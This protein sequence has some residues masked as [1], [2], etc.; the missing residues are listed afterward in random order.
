M[1]TAHTVD[2]FLGGRIAAVQPDDG[3]HR[4]G[5][6]AVLL[7]AAL[8]SSFV[9]T[10]VD[11]GAGA[12]VAGLC[13]AARCAAASVVLV[14]RDPAA[15]A[16]S[17]A[18]IALPENADVA[19]RVR[20]VAADIVAPEAQRV[21]AGLGRDFADA[22]ITNPPFN[23]GD[24]GTASPAPGRSSAHVLGDNVLD[25]WMRTAAS[26]LRPGGVLVVAFRAGGLPALLA[27][28]AGR[29]GALAIL[30]IHPRA[31]RPAHRVLVRGVKGSRTPT[32][33]L[34]GLTLH[35]ATGN[36]YL[37]NV[38]SMLRDGAGLAD[39]HPSWAL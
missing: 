11:L 20:I 15:L 9:G 12:G 8:P 1:T 21:A 28:L 19:P 13:A 17:T 29:F 14:E 2:R 39:M 5:L 31:D 32:T 22:V 24:A 34:P 25:A 6:E 33:L 36:A 10:V 27:T 35:D 38:E 30:P 23:A 3:S 26:V 4:S 7:G 37:P 16:V 18:T